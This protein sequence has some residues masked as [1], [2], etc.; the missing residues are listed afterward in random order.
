MSM[1]TLSL[2]NT[3]VQQGYHMSEVGITF[4]LHAKHSKFPSVCLAAARFD[5]KL[6]IR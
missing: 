5:V 3:K 6:Q 2:H 4:Y 1:V